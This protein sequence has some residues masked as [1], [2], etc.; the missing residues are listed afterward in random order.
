MSGYGEINALG[1]DIL[2]D[3]NGAYPVSINIEIA[4]SSLGIVLVAIT[5]SGVRAIQIGDDK[6]DLT[7]ELKQRFPDED[8]LAPTCTLSSLTEKVV[9]AIESGDSDATA[10]IPIDLRG[11]PFQKAV[12]RALREVPA[13][14]TVSYTELARRI[15]RPAAVRA[16]AHACATN[17]IAVLVPCHRA[18]RSDGSLAGYRWGLARK[19]TLLEREA[20]ATTARAC[21]TAAQQA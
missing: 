20:A 2:R 12:W 17:A 4:D 7:R 1:C 10:E 9:A 15:G 11:T 19:R 21:C 14:T 18:I 6:A 3:N 8:F 13:G 5:N 16:V